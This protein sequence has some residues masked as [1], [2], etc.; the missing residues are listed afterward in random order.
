MEQE[1]M[2]RAGDVRWVAMRSG[3]AVM[4][5]AG[6]SHAREAGNGEERVQ[7][8]ARRKDADGRGRRERG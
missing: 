2:R 1:G 3:V 7:G 5:V 8:R 4:C 6:E